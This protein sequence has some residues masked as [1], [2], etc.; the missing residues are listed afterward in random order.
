MRR[1]ISCKEASGDELANE[2][3][4]A[5]AIIPGAVAESSASE[6]C[7]DDAC[8]GRGFVDA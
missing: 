7:G 2:E 5:V 4:L 1:C 3:T 8:A 6:T